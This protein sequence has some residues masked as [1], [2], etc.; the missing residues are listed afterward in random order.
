MHRFGRQ[1]FPDGAPQHRAAIGAATGAVCGLVGITPCAG[2]VTSLVAAPVGMLSA[3][4]SFSWIWLDEH[5]NLFCWLDNPQ[6]VL[7]TH[8]ISGLVGTLLTGLFA[9]RPVN[10]H[11]VKLDKDGV[12]YG[13]GRAGSLRQL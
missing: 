7:A 4:A 8:G 1:E 10:V 6:D 2:Y 12:L 11:E 3:G 5:S 9:Y 13:G